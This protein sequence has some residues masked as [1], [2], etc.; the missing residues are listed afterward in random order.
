M[1]FYEKIQSRE[2]ILNERLL[3]PYLKYL[4]SIVHIRQKF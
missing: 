2:T 1:E 3:R 4:T